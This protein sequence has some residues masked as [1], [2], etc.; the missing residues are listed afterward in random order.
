MFIQ[1]CLCDLKNKTLHLNRGAKCVRQA[2]KFPLAVHE[3]SSLIDML[4]APPPPSTTGAS[5][6]LS[7]NSFSL[8]L[9]AQ[10]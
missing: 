6:A 4:S 5:L 8:S 7:P 2:V 3:H 10:Q 9:P 1:K